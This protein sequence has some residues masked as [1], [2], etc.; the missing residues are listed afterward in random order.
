MD[1]RSVADSFYVC[2]NKNVWKISRNEVHKRPTKMG[3]SINCARWLCNS[4]DFEWGT[5]V[6]YSN[7]YLPSLK[8]KS[9]LLERIDLSEEHSEP[10]RIDTWTSIRKEYFNIDPTTMMQALCDV[11]K[12]DREKWDQ[13]RCWSTGD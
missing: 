12:E 7:T 3:L 5:V 10:L 9:F 8:A 4:C 6:K 1:I 11:S 2:C 13:Q